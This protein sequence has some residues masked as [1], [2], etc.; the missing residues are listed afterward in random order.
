VCK[1][2]ADVAFGHD[3]NKERVLIDHGYASAVTLPHDFR[4]DIQRVGGGARRHCTRHNFLNFHAAKRRA[5]RMP[6][7]KVL[8]HTHKGLGWPK[9]MI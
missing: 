7:I 6:L 5:L 8:E 3:T 2:H 4:C 9:T 1:R